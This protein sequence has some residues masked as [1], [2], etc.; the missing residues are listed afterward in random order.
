MVNQIVT[1][2]RRFYDPGCPYEIPVP[3]SSL[4]SLLDDAAS[5]YPERIALDYFGKTMSYQY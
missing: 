5:F 2:A 1:E 4:F 3:K